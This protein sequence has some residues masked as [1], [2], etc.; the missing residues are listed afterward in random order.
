[1]DGTT[2]GIGHNQFAPIKAR[3]DALVAAANAWL[4]EVKEIADLDTANACDDF[5]NQIKAELTALDT[6]RKTL[7]KPHDEAIKANNDAFRPLTALLDKAKTLLTPLKTGW[8]KREQDRI[9]AEKRRAEEE[10]LRKMQEAEDA[11]RAAGSSVEAAVAA[12]DAQKAADEA[13]AQASRV[14]SL[15]PQVKGDH[16]ARASG[17]RTH[18]SAAITDYPKA[19][20]HYGNHPEVRAVVERLANADARDQKA[21]LQVPGVEPKSEQRAA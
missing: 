18:W 10:A 13:L 6:E 16:S 8:L 20:Q 4:G 5:L 2:P 19:L 7:N 1:M 17:L 11:K 3:V 9:A 15:K 14:A 21:A 12:D